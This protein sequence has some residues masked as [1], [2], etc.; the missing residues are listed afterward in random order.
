MKLLADSGNR[1]CDANQLNLVVF[2]QQSRMN[3]AQMATSDNANAQR[4]HAAL[5][6]SRLR[7]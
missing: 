5:L 4:L 7:P 2:G 6:R 1:F 3:P